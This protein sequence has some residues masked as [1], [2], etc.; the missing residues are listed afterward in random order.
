MLALRGLDVEV[1]HGKA[2]RHR[3]PFKRDT[4]RHSEDDSTGD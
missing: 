2:A 4:G 1:R 3:T